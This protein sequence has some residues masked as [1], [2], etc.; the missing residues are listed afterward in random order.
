MRTI[1]IVSLG[2]SAVLG[3]GALVIAKTVLPEQAAA[4]APRALEPTE[5]KPV[6]VA[7]KAL[8][9]GERL[10]AGQLKIVRVPA[11]AVPEGAFSSIP[12]ALAQD[13]GGAPV[14]LT[15]VAARE[16]LLPAKLSG[17]GARASVAAEIAEGMR[18]YAIK[19]DSDTGVGGHALPG[20]RVDVVLLR[21][22][23][24]GG[25]NRSWVSDVVLQ[26]V[27]VLAI[28][29]NA[30]LEANKPAAP[31]VATL[32]VSVQDS[33]KLAVAADL[34]KLSLALR[35]TGA[36]EIQ[37]IATLRAASFI[38]GAQAPARTRAPVAARPAEAGLILIVEGES[39]GGRRA[40]PKAAAAK[41]D[42]AMPTLDGLKS[43]AGGGDIKPSM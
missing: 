19:V 31:Q 22:Q 28:D 34:G 26:N 36:A 32:E 7:V 10:E 27:R 25:D 16:T 40:R 17:P 14:V 12:A 15:A 9:F 42:P 3:L 24:P 33:Q 4:R 41:P 21:D 13:H 30:D 6:V 23:T 18:A 2:A 39:A 11:A 35:K 5:G 37:P 29:L 8:K 38:A 1:T 20:D 43:S